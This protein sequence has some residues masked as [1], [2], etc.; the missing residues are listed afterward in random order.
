ME[1]MGEGYQSAHDAD[2]VRSLAYVS[3]QELATRVSH[4]NTGKVTNDPMPT[5]CSLGSPRTRT[6]T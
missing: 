6:C 5:S 2:L 3:F 4:R 1:H